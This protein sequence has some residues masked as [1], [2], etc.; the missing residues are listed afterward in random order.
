MGFLEVR[1][2]VRNGAQIRISER[3][4]HSSTPET[5][6]RNKFLARDSRTQCRNSAILVT[7]K[8][9]SPAGLRKNDR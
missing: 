4:R 9:F 1:S 2:L 7:A 6:S 8:A 3:L 5:A